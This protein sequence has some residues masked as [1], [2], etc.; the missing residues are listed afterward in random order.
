MG[1]FSSE[2]IYFL[3]D[4]YWSGSSFKGTTES[5]EQATLVTAGPLGIC[6]MGCCCEMTLGI[7]LNSKFIFPRKRFWLP[8][9]VLCSPHNQRMNS[10]IRRAW[11]WVGQ[12]PKVCVLGGGGKSGGFSGCYQKER[13]DGQT[14]VIVS[15]APERLRN[16][17]KWQQHFCHSRAPKGTAGEFQDRREPA[18]LKADT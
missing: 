8:T 7:C 14:N 9:K 2:D 1:Q 12:L 4:G 6:F 15:K 17:C 16:K 5:R 18:G 3:N 13:G 11:I 10:F